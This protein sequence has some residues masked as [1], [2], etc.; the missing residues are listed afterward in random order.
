VELRTDEVAERGAQVRRD[1]E[2]EIRD[3]VDAAEQLVLR[4]GDDLDLRR[5]DRDL[6][7][8]LRVLCQGGRLGSGQWALPDVGRRPPRRGP[9]GD[10]RLDA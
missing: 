7:A 9:T 3:E 10:Q 2:A 1:V 4:A 5:L 6:Q 8:R